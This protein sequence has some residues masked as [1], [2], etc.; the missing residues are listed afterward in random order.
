M[1]NSPEKTVRVSLYHL[2]DLFIG[3][4]CPKCG[5]EHMVTESDMRVVKGVSYVKK[6]E[7]VVKQKAPEFKVD[8]GDEV[9]L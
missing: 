4:K 5:H 8:V 7:P 3:L 2:I 6:D 9:E 1:S